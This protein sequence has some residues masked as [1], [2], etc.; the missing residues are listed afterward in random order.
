MLFILLI[1]MIS[2][3]VTANT[4][5]KLEHKQKTEL[6]KVFPSVD[7]VSVV[8]ENPIMFV[9][10]DLI[11]NYSQTTEKQS[12]TFTINTNYLSIVSDVGWYLKSV[13]KPINHN[14]SHCWRKG[15]DINSNRTKANFRI[16]DNC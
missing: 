6:T 15:I 11:K 2:L 1:G 14:I 10:Y 7:F 3:T 13:N 9:K 8:S 5:A 16:R 4:T 12:K